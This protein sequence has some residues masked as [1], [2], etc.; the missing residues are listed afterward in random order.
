[1]N[2]LAF[3]DPVKMFER[4]SAFSLD[5]AGADGAAESVAD[6]VVSG[7]ES[8]GLYGSSE[9]LASNKGNDIR[10]LELLLIFRR[11]NREKKYINH[12]ERVCKR[13]KF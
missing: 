1:M 5:S 4:S 7:S 9:K 8:S 12:I 10:R 13:I 6:G 2:E 3:T 11:I